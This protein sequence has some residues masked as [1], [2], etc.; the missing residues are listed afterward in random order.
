LGNFLGSLN[1]LQVLKGSLVSLENDNL[2]GH[3]DDDDN[4]NGA[5]ATVSVFAGFLLNI[6]ILSRLSHT[7]SNFVLLDIWIQF[8]SPCLDEIVSF[9]HVGGIVIF[10]GRLLLSLL[11]VSLVSLNG[12]L[13]DV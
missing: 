10:R 2:E 9:L 11:P 13:S 6:F 8:R 12:L 3:G 5:E 7:V 4:V 1:D